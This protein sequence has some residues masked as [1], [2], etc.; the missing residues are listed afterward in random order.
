MTIATLGLDLDKVWI[1]LV[2]LDHDAASRPPGPSSDGD[3]EPAPDVPPKKWT[4]G[5]AA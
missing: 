3:G 2:G 1:F 4:P 5:Y